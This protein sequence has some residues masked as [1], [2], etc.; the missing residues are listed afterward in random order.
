MTSENNL[1][2]SRGPEM[3]FLS[4]SFQS[5]VTANLE[6]L[7]GLLPGSFVGFSAWPPSSC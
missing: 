4:R 5:L 1:D 3:S 2:S 7:E 6:R